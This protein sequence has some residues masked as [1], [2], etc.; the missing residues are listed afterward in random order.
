MMTLVEFI[1][2]EIM[3]KFE[4]SGDVRE[5]GEPVNMRLNLCGFETP[6]KNNRV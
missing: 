6:Q 5:K 4:V 2:E 3:K 1:K